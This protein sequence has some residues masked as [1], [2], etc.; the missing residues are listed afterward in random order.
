MVKKDYWNNL[1]LNESWSKQDRF[2]FLMDK[3]ESAIVGDSDLA[4]AI[5][6]I[7]SRFENLVIPSKISDLENDSDFITEHQSLEDYITKSET[8]GL[9]KNDGTV[10][11]TSYISEH[12]DITGKIDRNELFSNGVFTT[13]NTKTNGTVARIWNESD[14][15]GVQIIDGTSDVKAFTGVNEGSDGSGIYAQIYAVDKNT[16]TGTRINV[17]DDG[18]FYTKGKSN[19]TWT[20]NDEI[21]TKQDIND[22]LARIE[23]LENK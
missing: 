18:V 2:N 17:T 10:D 16:K 7:K 6:N 20:T 11:T 19:Y 22:L 4:E 14:G 23:A 15:G 8:D 21:A 12:Q 9:V 3:I 13:E 1:K 5:N